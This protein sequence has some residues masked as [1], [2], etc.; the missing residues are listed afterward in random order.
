MKR[1]EYIFLGLVA[2][3]VVALIIFRGRN[4]LAPPPVVTVGESLTPDNA[5][6]SGGPAYLTSNQPWYFGPEVAPFLPALTAG[7]AGS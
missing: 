6:F 5:Q 4:P 3:A 2:A 1:S 7:R